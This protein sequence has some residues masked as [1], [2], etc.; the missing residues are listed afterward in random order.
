MEKIAWIMG[1][2]CIYWNDVIKILAVFGAVFCFLALCFKEGR[3][4]AA[5]VFVPLAVMSSLM[6]SRL[7]HWYFRPEQ[8]ESLLVALTDLGRGEFALM[9]AFAG[10]F[11]AVV[12]V[13]LVGLTKNLPEFLDCLSLAGAFG[14]GLGRLSAFFDGSCRGMLLPE[15]YGLPWVAGVVNPVSGVTEYRLATFLLQAMA[16]GGMFL[17]LLVWYLVKQKNRKDGDTALM[18]LLLYGASQ[19]I[20]DSTR[21]D[22][23]VLRSNGFLHA[24]QLL[25]S[26]AMVLTAVIFS[27]RLVRAGGWKKWHPALWLAQAG[28][29][30]LA[31]YMEYYV[32]RHGH[33][34]VFSYT[35]MGAA[36]AVFA[37][38]TL[39]TRYL[40]DRE[41]K[42]HN[43]WLR[44]IAVL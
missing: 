37:V 12:F 18:F 19:V 39:L 4:A 43:A 16:A 13:R 14:I 6:L 21:Y 7:T 10:C 24:V 36:L 25:G 3:A 27:V 23:L 31:G 26:G 42:A 2:S 44:Q 17:A 29:F 20:L 32:Q 38:L 11:L 33:E 40:A 5:M 9:G 28:C 1:Y 35:I 30:S 41:E 34:A 22:A 8:Y 15:V